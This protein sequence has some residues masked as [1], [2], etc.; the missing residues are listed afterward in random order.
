LILLR[1]KDDLTAATAVTAAVRIF[2][3]VLEHLT[4]VIDLTAAVR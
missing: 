2:F 3:V 4:A 1:Q